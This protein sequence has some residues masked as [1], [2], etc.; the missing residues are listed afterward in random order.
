VGLLLDL[1]ERLELR[2]DVAAMMAT[3]EVASC[4]FISGV[5]LRRKAS[6]GRAGEEEEER[7]GLEQGKRKGKRGR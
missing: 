2:E 1:D 6:S 4:E 7:Q 5:F 3:K